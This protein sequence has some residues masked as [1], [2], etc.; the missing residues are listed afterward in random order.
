MATFSCAS[1]SPSSNSSE[2]KVLEVHDSKMLQNGCLAATHIL[3]RAV[4]S[5]MNTIENQNLINFELRL[6]ANGA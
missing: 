5:T 2:G 3:L 1:H 4:S 6:Q